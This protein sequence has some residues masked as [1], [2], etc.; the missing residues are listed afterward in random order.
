[1]EITT[2][3]INNWL[4]KSNKKNFAA[5]CTLWRQTLIRG[6]GF[7]LVMELYEVNQ[8]LGHCFVKDLINPSSHYKNT[9]Q[10]SLLE[11]VQNVHYHAQVHHLS[12][13]NGLKRLA[14][15]GVPSATWISSIFNPSNFSHYFF[16][17]PTSHENILN[18]CVSQLTAEFTGTSGTQVQAW[19]LI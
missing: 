19:V 1:M 5:T 17:L 10:K 15:T 16:Q 7:P 2:Q 6:S 3:A 9:C 4:E 8:I 14:D 18:S 12:S 13:K 11:E